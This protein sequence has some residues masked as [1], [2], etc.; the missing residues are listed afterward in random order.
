[1][2]KFLTLAF[3]AGFGLAAIA[4]AVFWS[5]HKEFIQSNMFEQMTSEQIFMAFLWST[6]ISGVLLFFTI[7]LSFSSK[8]SH[9]KSI[10]ASYGGFATDNS[11]ILNRF[12][13]RKKKKG[14]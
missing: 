5:I 13:F 10:T 2:I 3:K 11:G 4:A 8:P 6:G 1:M 7:L 14:E 9:S 12:S